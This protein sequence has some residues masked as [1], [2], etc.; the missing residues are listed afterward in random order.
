MYIED[1]I[2]LF[3]RRIEPESAIQS[4]MEYSTKV[5]RTP[6]YKMTDSETF[7]S[8]LQDSF[9]NYSID[10]AKNVFKAV[11]TLTQDNPLLSDAGVF[12]LLAYSVRDMLDLD[13]RQECI[14]KSR[15]LL[16]F[17]KLS[18]PI[19]QML[20]VSAFL[21]Q[22]DLLHHNERNVFSFPPIVRTDNLRLHHILDKGMAENHFHIGGS[23]SSFLY[24]WISLMNHISHRKKEFAKT[25]MDM[26]PLDQRYRVDSIAKE[27][28][29]SLIFKASCIRYF[30]F[31]RLNNEWPISEYKSRL[32]YEELKSSIPYLKDP[33][34]SPEE[35]RRHQELWSNRWLS[36]LLNLSENECDLYASDMDSRFQALRICCCGEGPSH[37]VP[38]YAMAGDPPAPMDDMDICSSPNYAVRNFERRLYRSLAG[39]QRF[40]YQIFKAIFSKDEKIIPYADLVYAYLLIYCK[41]RGELIQTNSRVGFGNFLEYQNRKDDFTGAMEKY[42]LMRSCVAQQSVFLNP[43]VKYFEGRLM[44]TED[45]GKLSEKIRRIYNGALYSAE[46]ND[47]QR[48]HVK[49]CAENKLHYVLHFAKQQQD[50]KKDDA[51]FEMHNPR[52][53]KLR[54]KAITQAGAIIRARDTSSDIMCRVTGIDACS[55]EIG[56]RPEVFACAFRKIRQSTASPLCYLNSEIPLPYMRITYH[57]GE[58]FL[59]ISDGLR[60]MDEAIKFLEMKEGDRF[61]HALALGVDIEEWYAFKKYS[62]ILSKQ[63]HLDNI[64]WIYGKMQEYSIYNRSAEDY[65]CNEFRTLFNEIFLENISVDTPIY[66]STIMDYYHAQKLRGNDP[67]LYYSCPK[68]DYSERYPLFLQELK[69]S[70]GLAPWRLSASTKEITDIRS[71]LLYNNYHFNYNIK[72]VSSKQHQYTIPHSLICT[73]ADIQK[74]MQYDIARQGLAIECNPSSNYLIGTFRDYCKH[75]IFTFNDTGLLNMSDD[76]PKISVSINTDDL[77]IFDT[78]LENEYALLACALEQRNL[79]VP[80]DKAIP[81]ENIYNW[82]DH[83]RQMGCDQSFK[84]NM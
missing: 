65:L 67:Y 31:L 23:S 61:G 57:A 83:I 30:L 72:K 18:H 50:I 55:N 33:S 6:L 14:C 29:Y 42:A 77:G 58:D 20:F 3:M 15:E 32:R 19:C 82:L 60:A 28:F 5:D 26:F 51:I 34:S 35:M 66:Q 75:P 27:S 78:S 40:Q 56:C 79:T 10:E 39:E 21:A 54:K 9:N 24:S 17:R 47:S 1:S 16:N 46:Y 13:V 69:N 8:K 49:Q 48:E 62:V 44:P 70:Y 81:I 36:E 22:Y 84:H 59:D 74:K 43:Q 53:S 63:D 2:Y 11:Y 52:D 71:V 12:G 80:P 73:I 38:D 45:D 37:F 68:D 25:K 7:Y 76:N 4:W 64:A 41:L